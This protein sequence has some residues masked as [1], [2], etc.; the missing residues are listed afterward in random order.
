M[1]FDRGEKIRSLEEQVHQQQQSLEAAVREQKRSNM[2]EYEEMRV[3][4]NRHLLERGTPALLTRG[5]RH[6][7]AVARGFAGFG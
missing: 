2:A 7:P 1:L 5:S 6:A 3:E 4:A